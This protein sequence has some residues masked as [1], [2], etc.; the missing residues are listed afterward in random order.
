MGRYTQHLEHHRVPL[1]IAMKFLVV[2]SC[3]V[4]IVT[5]T[6]FEDCGSVAGKVEF[7]IESCDIPPCI[8]NRGTTLTGDILFTPSAD[9]NGL[10]TSIE[11]ELF[12][13]QLPWPGLD[14]N[15]CHQLEAAGFSCPI[16][17]GERVTWHL[18]QQILNEYP[19]VSTV[20]TFTLTDDGGNKQVCA[21]VPVQL[22]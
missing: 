9:S 18:E 8:V 6:A 3:V 21:K 11:A 22:V 7:N 19:A 4:A 15:G 17:S 5:A 14:T 13:M 2:L 12:G 1:T 16:S 20:A 10:T